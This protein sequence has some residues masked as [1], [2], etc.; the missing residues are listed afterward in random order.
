LPRPRLARAGTLSMNGSSELPPAVPVDLTAAPYPEI[1]GRRAR[2][3]AVSPAGPTSRGAMSGSS[4]PIEENTS[5][6]LSERN[7]ASR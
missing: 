6:N 5:C 4:A 3:D 7:L 2:E 1:I